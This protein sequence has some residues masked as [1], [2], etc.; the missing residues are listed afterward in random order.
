MPLT[1]AKKA[2]LDRQLT[3]VSALSLAGSENITLVTPN[4]GFSL[5]LYHLAISSLGQ[6]RFVLQQ[7]ST[8]IWR[9]VLGADNVTVDLGDNPLI[10]NVHANSFKMDVQQVAAGYY[11]YSF[12]YVLKAN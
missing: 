10:F 5:Y 12:G 4:P 2:S 6:F 8:N 1:I 3:I 11:A 9:I 7:G